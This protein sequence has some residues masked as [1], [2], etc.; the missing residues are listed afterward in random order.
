MLFCYTTVTGAAIS[1]LNGYRD[2][3]NAF[4]SAVIML[5]KS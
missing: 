4:M 1:M 3:E 5:K 2:I